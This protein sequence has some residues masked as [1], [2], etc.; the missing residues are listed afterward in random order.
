MERLDIPGK[1]TTLEELTNVVRTNAKLSQQGVDKLGANLLRAIVGRSI[2]SMAAL[3]KTVLAEYQASVRTSGGLILV[4]ATSPV[5][6]NNETQGAY[7]TL[8]VDDAEVMTTGIGT[9]AGLGANVCL[10]WF[11]DLPAGQHTFKL[12][13]QATNATYG[14]AT[15]DGALYVVELLKG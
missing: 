5:T 10:T 8:R 15:A 6:V 7:M 14:S 4:Y 1:V 13:G 2:V 12:F 3:T 9:T 11:G